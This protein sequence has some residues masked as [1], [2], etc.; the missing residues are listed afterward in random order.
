M[1]CKKIFKVKSLAYKN[2]SLK[3]YV[4]IQAVKLKITKFKKVKKSQVW[5][6]EHDNQHTT[7]SYKN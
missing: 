7:F 5:N 4:T 3:K 1:T 2:V 6:K